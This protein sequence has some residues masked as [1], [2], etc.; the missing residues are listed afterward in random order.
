HGRPASDPGY[1]DWIALPHEVSALPCQFLGGR[2]AAFLREGGLGHSVGSRG[3]D[4]DLA[5]RLTARL[6]LRHVYMPETGGRFVASYPESTLEAWSLDDLML[7][8]ERWGAVIRRGDPYMNA[9][10]SLLGEDVRYVNET[11]SQ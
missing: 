2:R 10:L 3:F 11:E 5:L 7:L 1:G 6:G 8:W 4:V 9:N